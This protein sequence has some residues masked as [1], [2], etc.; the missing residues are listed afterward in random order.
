[1]RHYANLRYSLIP[2]IKAL[3]SQAAETGLPLMRHMKL[4]FPDEPNA[5]TL[6]DHYILGPDLVVA[7]ILQEGVQTRVVYFP[8]GL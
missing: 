5:D 3:A 8:A 4:E 7:P 1:M 6:D 2:Y